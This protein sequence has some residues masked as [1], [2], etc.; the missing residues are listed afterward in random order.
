[1]LC[2]AQGYVKLHLIKIAQ[3]SAKPMQSCNGHSI[4]CT[5]DTYCS[6]DG[7]CQCQHGFTFDQ[8][9]DR[10]AQSSESTRSQSH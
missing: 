3:N 2:A 6:Q 4:V 9:N 5:G 7:K 10:C 8:K 1:M